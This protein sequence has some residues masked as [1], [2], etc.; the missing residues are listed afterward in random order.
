MSY[1]DFCREFRS[2][3]IAEIDDDASYVYQSYFDLEAE[4]AY[5][6]VEIQKPGSYSLQVDKTPERSFTGEKQN[7]YRYP[8]ATI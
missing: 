7:N 6:T 1:L 2:V 5:F 3:T 4:G 8:N